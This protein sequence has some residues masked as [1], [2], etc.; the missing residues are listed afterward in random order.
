MLTKKE[1][2][3]LQELKKQ[4]V[5]FMIVGLSAASLQ[6]A[7]VVTE[8]V[9]L[10]FQD[11]SNPKI[12]KTIRRLGGFYIPPM[13]EVGSPPRFA[14]EGFDFL[15]IVTHLS[16]LEL[17][18]KELK[19]TIGVTFEGIKLKILRLDRIIHSKKA[20]GR[21][22]DRAVLPALEAAWKAIQSQKKKRIKKSK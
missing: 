11:L 6:G 12:K 16:G 9:D 21:L 7:P 10:W 18:E 5:P 20:A 15:D 3:F 19:K 8:D 1:L 4:K 2:R 13:I 14:G 22:K 17:F